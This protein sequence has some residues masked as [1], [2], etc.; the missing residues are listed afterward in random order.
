MAQGKVQKLQ[1][2][3]L[4]GDCVETLASL[5][6][7][8]VDLVF[9]D[10]PYNLQLQG[11]LHRPDSSRVDAVDDAW[12]S[13]D[14]FAAY[15]RQAEGWLREC[16]RVL[17]PDGAIWVIGSYHNIFRIGRLLQDLDYWILNDVIWRKSNPMPNFRGRRFT[18]A[19]ETLIWAAKSDSSKYCF[20]YEAMKALNEGVQ[21]RS[22]WL[23]PICT[24]SERLK[25]RQGRKA[26][27]TQKPENLLARVIL[28]STRRG[29]LILDPFFGTG[30]TGAVA[31]RL[32]RQ[33]IGIEQDADYI[34][35]AKAR[36]AKIR[37]LASTVMMETPEKRALPRIPFGALLERGW[38][39]PGDQLT[40][41]GRRFTAQVRADGSLVAADKSSGSIHSLGASLQGAPS[42]NGWT[43]WHI[44]RQG[45]T[46]PIDDL[47]SALRA[48]MAETGT[49]Q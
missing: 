36:I 49:V 41:A 13:F 18:N 29:D 10:P 43:F 22:D 38:L 12:D 8:S 23:L 25:D 26:H 39:Q 24:G 46:V 34:R 3:I 27:P 40:D 35:L 21:M 45:K 17:K 31:R 30:T 5:P 37:P 2:Q 42:C 28:A 9:A 32:G 14:S 11:E 7:A 44:E 6:D 4:Q 20:N 48:E 33:F 16:R 19:H 15:D 1:D 47:R